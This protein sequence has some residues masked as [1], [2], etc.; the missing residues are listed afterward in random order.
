[1]YWRSFWSKRSRDRPSATDAL[2]T[3]LCPALVSFF[4]H[5]LFTDTAEDLTQTAL[6]RITRAFAFTAGILIAV[7]VEELIPRRMRMGSHGWDRS[8]W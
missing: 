4:A 6:L 8:R 2:L 1:M 3:A 5:R 7:A